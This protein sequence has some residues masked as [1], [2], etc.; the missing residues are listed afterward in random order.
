MRVGD[1]VLGLFHLGR[2][3]LFAGHTIDHPGE[4]AAGLSPFRFP[5][6]DRLEKAV[7]R[8]I[9]N[10]LDKLDAT[11][12]YCV[13]SCGAGILFGELMRDAAPSCTS[14]CPSPW[15]TS[16]ARGSIAACPRWP[17]G[18]S[19]ARPC[20]VQGGGPLRHCGGLP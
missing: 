14:S 6:D 2:C 7:A 17:T 1:D 18:A 11:I 3:V 12:G 5:A 20:W 8:A 10:E 19:A 15:R 16:T 13:P 9:E 4:V